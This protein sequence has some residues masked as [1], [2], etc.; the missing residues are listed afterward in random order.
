MAQRIQP[1]DEATNGW[2]RTGTPDLMAPRI[3]RLVRQH[4]TLALVDNPGA[5]TSSDK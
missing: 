4:E 1:L 3:M 5:I 2:A